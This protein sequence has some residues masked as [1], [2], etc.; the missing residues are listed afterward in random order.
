[1]NNVQMI[2]FDMD[3]LLLDTEVMYHRGWLHVAHQHGYQLKKEDIMGWSGQGAAHTFS[4]MTQLLGS[5]EV[6]EQLRDEREDYIQEELAKGHVSVKPYALETLQL[7]QAKGIKTGLASSTLRGRGMRYLEHFQLADYFDVITFGDDVQQL[8]PA[9][10]SYLTTV[11]QA[12]VA[13]SQAL[14]AEDS[15]TG[16]TAATAAGL[17]VVLVPDQS[18][19]YELTADQKEALNIVMESDSLKVLYDH[20]TKMDPP[21]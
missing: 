1:M 8:K 12:G 9:P 15:F 16:A 10:D 4:K 11:S 13:P 14:A 17:G 20:L 5:P 21:A 6:V 2:V 3:G 19:P 7:A 18:M